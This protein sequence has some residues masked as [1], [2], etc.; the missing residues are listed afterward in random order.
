MGLKIKK[1]IKIIFVLVIIFIVGISENKFVS[2]VSNVV[3][4]NSFVVEGTANIFEVYNETTKLGD[5]A[6]LASAY[7]AVPDGGTISITSD[8]V[9]NK[10]IV[11]KDKSITI[12][13]NGFTVDRS[14]FASLLL[15]VKNT[16]GLTIKNITFDGGAKGFEVDYDAI[17][18]TNYFIPLKEG[19][20]DSDP[21]LT[22]PPIQSAG[23]LMVD[24][25]N[26]QNTYISKNGGGIIVL[27]GTAIIENSNFLHNNANNNKGRAGAIMAGS[28]ISTSSTKYPV[29]LIH[30]K[31]CNFENNYSGNGGAIYLYNVTNLKIEDSLFKNNI[32]NGGKGGAIAVAGQN[33]SKATIAE[34]IGLGFVQVD[35]DNTVFDH[36]GA[37]NDGFA[38]QSYEGDLN[39]KNSVFKGN[40]GVHPSSSVGT[41]SLESYRSIQR[42][43]NVKIDGCLFENNVGP[44]SV[45]GDHATKDAKVYVSNSSFVGNEGNEAFLFYSSNSEFRDVKF[46]DDKSKLFVVEFRSCYSYTVP[47]TLLI[48]NVDIEST[49]A[50]FGLMVKR[51]YHLEK[52]NAIELT[53]KGINNT[54]IALWD[55]CKG[56]IEGEIKGTLFLDGA[57]P[58][59]SLNIKETA[60]IKTIETHDNTKTLNLYYPNENGVNT[61]LILYFDENIQTLTPDEL[62]WY[63]RLTKEGYKLEYYYDSSYKTLF[64]N[65]ASV[66]L[67]L[68]AKW[69][70]HEHTEDGELVA[71]GHG[72][73][74]Q[75]ACGKIIKEI[76]IDM[77]D[78]YDYDGKEKSAI[79]VNTLNL[80]ENEYSLTYYRKNSNGVWV[81]MDSV[82]KQ[83]GEYKVE[84]KY[85]DK[86]VSKVYKINEGVI[87]PNTYHGIFTFFVVILAVLY[88]VFILKNVI[89]KPKRFE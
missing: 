71:F 44:A 55:G 77:V 59:S 80:K 73:Y 36:N 49:T 34:Q 72:I 11:I 2:E 69:V 20:Q 63:H 4:Y 68:Y 29:D 82:P 61:E 52:Y 8:Y 14:T 79:L 24:N 35:I 67:V 47:P 1:Y 76:S 62:F 88:F 42:D 46:I 57:T 3:Y 19:S 43:I 21:L 31:N 23:N 26:F 38:I 18:H 58:L 41:I 32:A 54:D 6:D 39:I 70:E 7:A 50:K 74:E 27:S 12:D 45:F 56:N 85:N 60:K 75:C 51:Y 87:N 30:I 16:G 89:I 5:Y 64:D 22:Y 40:F 84:L 65:D 86:I 33:T 48:N 78:N 83:V 13:G 17:T 66:S 28:S 37:G 81:L 15:D 10:G 9:P 53:V 25:V